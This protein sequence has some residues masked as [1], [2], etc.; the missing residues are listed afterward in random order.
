MRRTPPQSKNDE[1]RTGGEQEAQ[2]EHVAVERGGARDVLADDGD[3]S[4]ARLAESGHGC[5]PSWAAE[6]LVSLAKEIG[7]LVSLAK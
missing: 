4:D 7:Q 3:L 2:A 1:R 5:L 6:R